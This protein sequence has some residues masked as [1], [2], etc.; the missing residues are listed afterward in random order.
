VTVTTWLRWPAVPG[1]AHAPR[2]AYGAD[3]NPE[4]WPRETWREDVELMREAGVNLVN[5]GIFSWAQVRPSRT[6]RCFE[7]L[8]EVFDLLHG[9]GIAVDLGTGTSSPPPWLTEQHPE[10]LPVAADGTVVSPGW[11]AALAADL[12]GLPRARARPRARDGRAV[13]R[14][15]GWRCGTSRTSSAATTCMT[16]RTTP[17]RLFACG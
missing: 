9:A 4:Q 5:L 10:I 6:E 8:D 17:R 15:P 2:F 12:A 16:T 3:Y 11:A 14:A 7:W 1:D 13:R